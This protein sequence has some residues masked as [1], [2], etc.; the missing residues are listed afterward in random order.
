MMFCMGREEERYNSQSRI[1]KMLIRI[2]IFNISILITY[3]SIDSVYFISWPAKLKIPFFHHNF[4]PFK[5]SSKSDFKQFEANCD[6]H[7]KILD[8]FCNFKII[9]AQFLSLPSLQEHLNAFKEHFFQSG[10]L[11]QYF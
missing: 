10:E 6:H 8:L 9:Y 1:F 3:L 7:H 11:L 4:Y 5:G 2:I